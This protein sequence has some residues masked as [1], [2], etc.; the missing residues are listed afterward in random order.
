MA[1]KTD[2][3]VAISMD[4]FTIAT[5]VGDAFTKEA[6]PVKQTKGSAR[7]I[8]EDSG[9]LAIE[10]KPIPAITATAGK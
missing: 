1:D 8:L 9:V 6:V 7:S 2:G 3:L 4:K 5:L 10:H